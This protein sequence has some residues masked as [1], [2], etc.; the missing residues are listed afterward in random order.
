[1]LRELEQEAAAP[2][3]RVVELQ[4][5]VQLSTARH[6]GRWSR[7]VQASWK[8]AGYVAD[9]AEIQWPSSIP[10]GHL[11]GLL[12][13]VPAGRVGIALGRHPV[14]EFAPRLAF[15]QLPES[16]SGA[17]FALHLLLMWLSERGVEQTARL[18]PPVVER[19][20]QGRVAHR[21]VQTYGTAWPLPPADGV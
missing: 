5:I 18:A 16:V 1:M 4:P 12:V 19:I 20:D 17:D 9:E 2:G 21:E 3:V 8:R 6:Y 11:A 15:A 14:P 7:G 10:P 13:V